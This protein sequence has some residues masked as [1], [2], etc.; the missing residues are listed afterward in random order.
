MTESSVG[1]LITTKVK[2]TYEADNYHFE[3]KINNNGEN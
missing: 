2:Y 1:G 3:M